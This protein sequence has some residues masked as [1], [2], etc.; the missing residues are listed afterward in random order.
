MRLVKKMVRRT[1][2]FLPG[3]IDLVAMRMWA[4]HRAATPDSCR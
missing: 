1:A 3:V 4:G 2:A